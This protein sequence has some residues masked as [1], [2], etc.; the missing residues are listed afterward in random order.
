MCQR[1][2]EAAE[3]GGDQSWAF[4]MLF[5]LGLDTV[6][7]GENLRFG[8]LRHKLDETSALLGGLQA[9]KSAVLGAVAD[10]YEQGSHLAV[11]VP[12]PKRL[13]DAGDPIICCSPARHRTGR[14]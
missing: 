8:A 2:A 7:I 11:T 12:A 6:L 3:A 4:A 10:W 5:E 9:D 1:Q 14:R 13:A